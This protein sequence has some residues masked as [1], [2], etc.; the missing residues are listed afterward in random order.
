MHPSHARSSDSSCSYDV[1][2][3]VKHFDPDADAGI[4]SSHSSLRHHAET[5]ADRPDADRP[6]PDPMSDVFPRR[7]HHWDHRQQTPPVTFVGRES[8]SQQDNSAAQSSGATTCGSSFDHPARLNSE[9]NSISEEGEAATFDA[10]PRWRISLN[11]I[12]DCRVEDEAWRR[13]LAAVVSVEE[14]R[15]VMLHV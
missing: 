8:L 9:R 15:L 12:A 11:R 14:K 4:H 10:L 6:R 3:G 7:T 2:C 1:P 13:W 5:T